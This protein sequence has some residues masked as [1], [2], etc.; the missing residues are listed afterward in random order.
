MEAE[1]LVHASA[2]GQCHRLG[3]LSSGFIGMTHQQLHL[4]L[5]QR[6]L[7]SRSLTLP[8]KS[9]EQ[10]QRTNSPEP[11]MPYKD[12]KRENLV[13]REFMPSPI[14]VRAAFELCLVKHL[15]IKPQQSW[16]PNMIS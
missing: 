5:W 6:Q 9:Y 2:A 1:R 16:R 11:Q 7:A 8:A 14:K 3:R 10:D 4:L 12:L 13:R 15:Q